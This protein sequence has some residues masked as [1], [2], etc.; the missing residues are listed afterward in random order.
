MNVDHK[1]PSRTC[2]SDPDFVDMGCPECGA[3]PCIVEWYPDGSYTCGVCHPAESATT[4]DELWQ[5]MRDGIAMSW[6]H[7]PTY[8]GPDPADTSGVWSWDHSRL[9]TGT[10]A[11][12]IQIVDRAL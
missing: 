4:L 5:L 12:D 10:C 1:C 9:I 11:D 8:G 3:H 2:D 6:E 7:L